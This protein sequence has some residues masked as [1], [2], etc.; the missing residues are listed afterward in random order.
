MPESHPN[1]EVPS[2][3][4]AEIDEVITHY[5]EKRSASLMVLHA[6]QDH[7]GFLSKEA[8]E[9]AAQKLELQPIN[10]YELV[11][12]Y[13]MF[14]EEPVGT[15]ILKICRTLSCAVNGAHRLHH[16]VCERLGL[17]PNSHASQ[18]TPDGRITVEYAECLASCGTAPVMMCN[19]AFYENVSNEKADDVI[20]ECGNNGDTETENKEDV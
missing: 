6:L 20:E 3:L 14:H 10:L 2:Q 17:D 4:E 19:A 16:H 18:T 8:I 13:P 1:F 9:W 15:Y 5:P 11:T 7:F 12:F